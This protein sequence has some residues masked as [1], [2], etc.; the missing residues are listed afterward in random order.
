MAINKVEFG[1]QTLID[2]TADTVT[3]STLM[4][5]ETAHDR[6][7]AA[8]VGTAS[9]GAV[10]HE[11][12]HQTNVEIYD[13]TQIV[14]NLQNKYTDPVVF[15]E[16]P[17]PLSSW[18]GII[19]VQ[20]ST[21][22]YDS[23]NDTL[24]FNVYTNTGQT[25]G[26]VDWVVM[27]KVSSGGSGSGSGY[28]VDVLATGLGDLATVDLAHPITD[29][30]QIMLIGRS[31]ADSADSRLT[32]VY[33]VAYIT[34]LI[35]TSTRFGVTSNDWFLWYSFSDASTMQKSA[36]SWIWLETVIGIKYQ[37]GGSSGGSSVIANPTETPTEHLNSV[38]IDGVVYD[39]PD[40]GGGDGNSQIIN[41]SSF[42]KIYDSTIPFGNYGTKIEENLNLTSEVM[43][44]FNM[45]AG[46]DSQ[47][48]ASYDAENQ[49]GAYGGYEFNTALKLDHV[50]FYLGRY[51]G[52]NLDLTVTAQYLDSSGTWHDVDDMVISTSISYP[53]CSF[54]VDFS[55][56]EKVYGV[57]WCHYKNPEKSSSNNICFFGMIMYKVANVSGGGSISYGYAVPQEQASDGSLYY[58]LSSVNKKIGEF[59]YMV[60][61]W[62]L[63]AGT[64][65]TKA[66]SLLVKKAQR[67]YGEGAT[68]YSVTE[69][70]R[71]LGIN[72]NINSSADTQTLTAPITGGTLVDSVEL[73]TNYG[74][75]IRNHVSN[76]SLID[77][78][79]GDTITLSNVSNGNY[80]VQLHAIFETLGIDDVNDIEEYEYL[81]KTDGDMGLSKTFNLNG[82]YLVLCLESSWNSG[83]DM[84]A[85]IEY[86]GTDCIAEY[87]YENGI[88]S[89]KAMIVDAVM[90]E[91]LT[92]K[93]ADKSSFVSRGY[94]IYS[95]LKRPILT[96][97]V[98][99]TTSGETTHLI[100]KDGR[101]LVLVSYSHECSHLITLPS[102]RTAIASGNIYTSDVGFEWAIVELKTNDS[103]KLSAT[104]A[105]WSAFSKVIFKLDNIPISSLLTSQAIGDGTAQLTAPSNTNKYLMV[106]LGM[107][108]SSSYPRNDTDTTGLTLDAE[109]ED[110]VGVNTVLGIYY[111][112]GNALPTGS[113]YGYDGGG[114]FIGL[115]S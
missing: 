53:I 97:V 77:A 27:D 12:I 48:S 94:F 45:N 47:H 66:L 29:Y 79:N 67:N 101:Y 8:I 34:P 20:T 99:D 37:G 3:P 81:I 46:W 6:S 33:D 115:F 106:G 88:F 43:M 42:T 41:L 39:I 82:L 7:G 113:F 105:W 80:V 26:Y 112:S 72:I 83:T 4:A 104:P 14:L 55:S 58:L 40:G 64:S 54:D 76:V 5:G 32:S 19:I 61:Q 86:S 15:A 16:N 87:V 28:K 23:A 65:F 36:N 68:T 21:V 9:G 98:D 100:P 75:S 85:D 92:L 78:S 31:Q 35:G 107:G 18:G 25:Y 89:C 95:L 111:A 93:W 59:L 56:L 13:N 91:T 30:D 52:Q 71:L 103:V 24:T 110:T 2:L 57:R 50:R 69:D 84:N 22:V 70:S 44:A 109:F 90:S 114:G 1:G 51:S 38:E 62:V 96:K 102:G 11:V 63:V 60:N 17:L 73:Q 10:K 49:T 74:N 108:R